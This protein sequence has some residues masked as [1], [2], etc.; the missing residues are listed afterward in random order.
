M[1]A[2]LDM[3]WLIAVHVISAILGL[4][5]AFAFPWVLRQTSSIHEMRHNLQLVERLEIFPK[6]FGSLALVSG[7]ALFFIGSYGPILQLWI[8]GSLI[9]Y[10]GA[11]VVVIGFM[12]PA[13]RSLQLALGESEAAAEP[14]A[15]EGIIRKYARVRSLH[16]GVGVLCMLILLLMIVKPL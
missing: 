8:A 14:V 15:T 11:Q 13:V 9:L 5:P 16:T 10:V 12:A 4:G 7:L 6:I 3:I 1:K 2:V